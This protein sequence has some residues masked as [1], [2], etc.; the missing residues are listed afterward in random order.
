MSSSNRDHTPLHGDTTM[1]QTLAESLLAEEMKMAHFEVIPNQETISYKQ[2]PLGQSSSITEVTESDF[3]SMSNQGEWN[4]R[5]NIARIRAIHTALSLASTKGMVLDALQDL[6]YICKRRRDKIIQ[7]HNIGITP[8]L[9]KLLEFKDRKVRCVVLEILRKLAEDDDQGKVLIG[10]TAAITKTVKMLSSNDQTIRHTSLLLLLELSK[11][12]NLSDKIGGTNGAILLLIRTKYD[13]STDT[14]ASEAADQILMNL[15]QCPNNVKCMAENGLIKPLLDNLTGGT[16]EIK[17]EMA[18]YLGEMEVAQHNNTYVAERASPV[19][20]QMVHGGN[21]LTRK[22]AFKAL[23]KI[24]SYRPNGRLLVEAGILKL[25]VDEMFMRKIYNEP[26]DSLE[27]ALG[28]LA[29]ILEGGLD[30]E[31]VELNKQG[32]TLA[33][34][35]VIFNINY[36]IKHSN[37]DELNLNLIRILSCLTKYPKS[38]DTIV[39]AVKESEASILLVELI[40]NPNEELAL[41]AIKL[42]TTL[43]PHMGHTLVDGLCKIN[44][45]P[46]GLVQTAVNMSQITEKRAL[47][48]KFLAKLP[49]QNLTLNLALISHNIVPTI[50]QIIKQIRTHGATSSR[51][52]DSYLEGLVG[53][54]VRLTATLYEPQVLLLAI[55][56]N[57]TAV[58]TGLLME[59][60]S[61]EIK[62][63]AANGLQKLSSQ[64]IYL[65]KLPVKSKKFIHQFNLSRFLSCGSSRKRKVHLC[66]VHRGVC[67]SQKTF[68]LIE[69]RA[70]ESLLACLDQ[71]NIQL[72]EA[73]LSAICTLLDDKV[74]VDKSVIM[75]NEMNV[76]QRVMKLVRDHKKETILQKMLWMIDKFL[77]K[78]GYRSASAISQDSQFTTVLVTAFHHGDVCTRQMA[79]K[80]LRFLD[81]MPSISSAFTL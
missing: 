66:S 50:L 78:D 28:I 40:T 67:S 81:K 13:R 20:I 12:L 46:E 2:P 65:S 64:S 33:S 3:N 23:V 63:L 18:N 54:L 11:V 42:L 76:V 32:H 37:P 55:K 75:L 14:F 34:D 35:Y 72:V 45:Q 6:E 79:E 9:I 24:S 47:S 36:M 29:N 38:A 62:R 43:S 8:L 58:L 80:I 10:N 74:D 70:I 68:C 77:V 53:I 49:H 61:D 48:A 56:W 17:L 52:A 26:M 69:A 57:F 22:A 19:L 21:S 4:E 1:V 16:E 59:T 60:S 31:D 25:M 51:H 5:N 41:A 15:A 27:E 73:A 71:Q 39:S 7:V 30:L 44:G